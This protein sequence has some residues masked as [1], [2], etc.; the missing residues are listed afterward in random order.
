[1]MPADDEELAAA[2]L[3][4]ITDEIQIVKGLDAAGDV[5]YA[6]RFAKINGSQTESLIDFLDGLAL[7]E[8][9]KLCFIARHASDE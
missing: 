4:V 1:M 6:T 8:A 9:A 5:V 2:G 7:L 3:S